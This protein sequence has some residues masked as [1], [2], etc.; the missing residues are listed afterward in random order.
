MFWGRLLAPC[1]GGG[2]TSALPMLYNTASLPKSQIFMA[3]A[4]RT[5]IPRRCF[6]L[7]ML[8]GEISLKAKMKFP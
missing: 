5:L 8:C 7:R 6:V 4:V 3:T 1:N 2:M